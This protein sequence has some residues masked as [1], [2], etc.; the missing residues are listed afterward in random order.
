M[1]KGYLKA[2]QAIWKQ[3]FDKYLDIRQELEETD[4]PIGKEFDELQDRLFEAEEAVLAQPAPDTFAVIEKLRIIWDDEL[5]SECDN[6]P[7][8]RGVIGDLMRLEACRADAG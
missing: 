5:F 2:D 6:G 3:T 4:P 7:Y 1:P 8:K